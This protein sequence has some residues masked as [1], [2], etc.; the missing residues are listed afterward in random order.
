M[1]VITHKLKEVTLSVLPITLI[2]LL[3]NFTIVPIGISL[4]I[5]FMIGVAFIIVGLSA[6]LFGIDLGI[7]PIGT[8]MG[9][10]ITKTNKIFLVALSGLILGFFISIAEPDLH[11]LANQIALVTMGG[12]SKFLIVTVVSIGIAFMLSV[13][14]IRIVYNFPLYKLLFIVYMAILILSLLSSKEI[15]AIAFDA[16]GATTGALTVPFI[17][18]LGLGVAKLKKDSKASEKDSFGLVALASTGAI[19][20]MMIAGIFSKSSI[21]SSGLNTT[22]L[23]SQSVFKPF[24]MH[25]PKT[26]YEIALA[27][28]PLFVLFVLS[29]FFVIKLDKKS[30]YKITKGVIYTFLGLVL[31]MVG[32]NGSFMEIGTILGF[33]LAS[34][35]NNFYLLLVGFVLGIATILAEPAVYVL[36]HQIED[37]TS[38]YVRKNDV[39][40]AISVGVGISVILSII[41]V[42]MPEVQLWHYLLPGYAISLILMFV[43]PKLFIGIAFDSGGVASGP[44]TATFIL[45]FVQGAA[46][47]IEHAN[48]LIDGFGMIALVALAPIIA[49]QLLGLIYKIKTVKEGI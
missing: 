40:F 1:N 23:E 28:L 22:I 48:V 39:L 13:G 16:S 7:T 14:M 21:V 15:L 42:L 19:L 27:I 41:R 18:A 10:M 36:T 6:F 35:D 37:V 26:S 24:I 47:K 3:L 43:V 4:M 30:F 45:A 38:G 46:D 17:L 8:I 25:L 49:L 12:L 9:S 11:I 33:R 34:L 31:F 5:R 2:V 29:N 20:F 44:M 32:V